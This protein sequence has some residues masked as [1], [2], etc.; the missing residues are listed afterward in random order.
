IDRGR[1]RQRLEITVRQG[2][3]DRVCAFLSHLP[4]G[5]RVA[6]SLI[7][8][9]PSFAVEQESVVGKAGVSIGVSGSTQRK[10][11]R[12]LL[13]A[14]RDT[15]RSTAGAWIQAGIGAEQASGKRVRGGL[16][17]GVGR[18]DEVQSSLCSTRVESFGGYE[19]SA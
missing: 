4:Q 6:R 15:A 19:R 16:Q 13:A 11:E 17:I 10:L 7:A 1:L 2:D 5:A 18:H 14:A 12:H 8:R 3:A 9:E